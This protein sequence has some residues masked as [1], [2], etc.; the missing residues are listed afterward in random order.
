MRE[1]RKPVIVSEV[2][3][4]FVYEHRSES[5]KLA[6]FLVALNAE[7]QQASDDAGQPPSTVDNARANTVEQTA[8]EADR[9]ANGDGSASA[10][11]AASQASE[12][13][14]SKRR[15]RHLPLSI[16]LGYDGWNAAYPLARHAT[17]EEVLEQFLCSFAS[18]NRI[19]CRPLG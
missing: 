13:D 6:N 3:F 11:H 14:T 9:V 19:R 4:N 5:E 16:E 10:T 12:A 1:S 15:M 7:E 2:V 17:I 18:S 8:V